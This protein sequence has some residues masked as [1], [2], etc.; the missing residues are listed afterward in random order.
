LLLRD[1]LI[2]P[3]KHA[4][5]WFSSAAVN[6]KFALRITSHKTLRFAAAMLKILATWIRIGSYYDFGA[7]GLAALGLQKA[8]GGITKGD[9]REA[10]L[11]RRATLSAAARRRFEAIANSSTSRIDEP[12]VMGR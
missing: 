1:L 12:A 8:L 7:H 10:Q 9:D 3:E 11:P 6:G 4:M 2:Q 5:A